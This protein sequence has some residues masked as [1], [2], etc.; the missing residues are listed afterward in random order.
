MSVAPDA[1]LTH[2]LDL[3]LFAPLAP[4]QIYHLF[5]AVHLPGLTGRADSDEQ[6]ALEVCDVGAWRGRLPVSI[7]SLGA[8]S[9]AA[10]R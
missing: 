7:V 3:S 9:S 10:E 2:E 1:E 5:R 8:E 6:S 4:E